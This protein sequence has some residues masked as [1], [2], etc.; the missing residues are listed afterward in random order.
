MKK[1]LFLLF[2]G[3]LFLAACSSKGISDIENGM[4][5]KEVTDIAGEP[6]DKV[7]MPLDIEWWVYEEDNV[8]L[9][10]EN[11]SVSRVTSE[12]ELEES[13]NDVEEGKNE[14]ENQVNELTE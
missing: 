6:N 2:A 4:S 12:K 5:A 7:S 11:D 10:M 3:A 8:L 9:I 14:I 1:K 13:L